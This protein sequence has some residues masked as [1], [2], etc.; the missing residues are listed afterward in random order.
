M[1]AATIAEY[2]LPGKGM[3]R[4]GADVPPAKVAFV[5]RAMMSH[6]RDSHSRFLI[7]EWLGRLIAQT[8]AT[9]SWAERR[10]DRARGVGDVLARGALVGRDRRRVVLGAHT[11]GAARR[12]TAPV[13][14]PFV[15]PYAMVLG[16]A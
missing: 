16:F 2:F 1:L 15:G 11:G 13:R 7:S 6:I 12:A 4:L 10:P 3:R 5:V 14:P 9:M 8:D